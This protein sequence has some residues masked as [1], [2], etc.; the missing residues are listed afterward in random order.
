[1]GGNVTSGGRASQWTAEAGLTV[2]AAVAHMGCPIP[3]AWNLLIHRS[4]VIWER[5][6]KLAAASRDGAGERAAADHFYRSV[7]GKDEMV[8]G[9]AERVG[10][11]LKLLVA[12]DEFDGLHFGS[13]SA[14]QQNKEVSVAGLGGLA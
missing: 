14:T 1:M 12:A 7:V 13:R 6:N 3:S 5:H 8:V 11:G 2:R 4:H 9:G 10:V